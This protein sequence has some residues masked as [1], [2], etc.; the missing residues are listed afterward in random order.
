MFFALA[1]LLAPGLVKVCQGAT[2]RMEVSR[3]CCSGK[4]K[5]EAHFKSE[6]CCQSSSPSSRTTVPVPQANP[7]S[8]K[9]FPVTLSLLPTIQV[10][11][12]SVSHPVLTL[13]FHAPPPF[14]AHH[15]FLC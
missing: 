11:E 14:L 8:T 1:A 7:E 10:G 2:Q 9:I 3:P 13:S 15:A 5:C 6:C 12:P 4:A